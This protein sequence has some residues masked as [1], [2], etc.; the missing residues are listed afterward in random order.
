[1]I[2]MLMIRGGLPVVPGVIGMVTLAFLGGLFLTDYTTAVVSFLNSGIHYI[3]YGVESL[4]YWFGGRD[5]MIDKIVLHDNDWNDIGTITSYSDMPE[6]G[7][8]H[9]VYPSSIQL[10]LNSI[11][12]AV[13]IPVG[14][15]TAP[16]ITF[17]AFYLI[18]E[19]LVF[20]KVLTG[21]AKR[22]EEL[23]DIKQRFER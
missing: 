9:T 13:T 16:V 3:Q 4:F 12:N 1:M 21:I 22:G 2:A 19:F 17:M 23:P 6:N 11:F 8:N 14:G 18:T 7:S 10:T 20:F 15:Q 5:I